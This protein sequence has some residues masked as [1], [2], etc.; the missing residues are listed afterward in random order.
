MMNMLKRNFCL[1]LFK[2]EQNA[3]ELLPIATKHGER[4]PHMT[5]QYV[6]GSKYSVVEDEKGRVQA[7]KNFKQLKL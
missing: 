5:G 2:L 7:T 1:L 4:D 6:V 3:S